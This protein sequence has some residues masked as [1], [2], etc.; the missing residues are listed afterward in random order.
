MRVLF[1]NP[2]QYVSFEDEPS[3]YQLRLPI[4]H[5]GIVD[6]HHD[7]VY[8][9][10]LRA[11]GRD[12]MDAGV[13]AAVE[14]FHPDVVVHS[15]TWEHEN[16]S[17]HVLRAVRDGGTPVVSMLW[18]SWIEPTS[19]EVGCL[20]GSTIL[21]VADSLNTYL[22]C[23]SV[24]ETLDPVVDVVFA[25]GQVWTDLIRPMPEEEKSIDVL[26][27][28]SDEGVRAELTAHLAEALPRRGLVFRRAGGLVDSRLGPFKRTASWVSWP[29]YARL[30]NRA[31]LCLCSAT[32]PT[33]DQIK[34]KIF[35]HMASGVACLTNDSAETRLFIPED[36]VALFSD[37]ED[38]VARIVDLFERPEE[39][40]EIAERG[41]SWLAETFDY[42]R[43]WSSVLSRAVTG[44]GDLPS[45]PVLDSLRRETRRCRELTVRR[46]LA[47][48][49]RAAAA[50]M[51]GG[52]ERL[53]PAW[54]GRR[55]GHHVLRLPDG[56][57]IAT[58]TMPLDMWTRA[59]V[60]VAAGEGAFPP[61]PLSPGWTPVAGG[62]AR[63]GL[64]RDE[65]EMEAGFALP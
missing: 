34:G 13:L 28:G 38:C 61:V 32:D 49:R 48:A 57:L 23:R 16:I 65:R 20:T 62:R 60:V 56:R 47:T 12:A 35:D 33:R 10:D 45:L 30:I 3:N 6:E 7:H 5:C 59:G 27:L 55:D 41:R 25:A 50:A 21:V 36:A 40:R 44:S 22:R 46:D 39:R 64:F 1:L 43:F 26:L 63:V 8:Q 37:K 54:L 42:K 58:S 15:A 51:A 18:D 14:R 52:G 11:G 17:P 29:E 9:R 24:G 2:E 31:R 4:L 19:A 53:S